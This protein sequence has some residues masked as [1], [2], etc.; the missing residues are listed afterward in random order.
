MTFPIE[1]VVSD[2]MHAYLFMHTGVRGD[3]R[4]NGSS[5]MLTGRLEILSLLWRTV[6]IEGFDL[7]EADLACVGL[8]YQYADRVGTVAA[9]G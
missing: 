8:G 3:L 5:D 4:L 9:L 6:C 1:Q 7:Y 2:T